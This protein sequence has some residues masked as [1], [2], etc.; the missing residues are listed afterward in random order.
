MIFDSD[1][2]AVSLYT[3]V[4]YLIFADLIL[5]FIKRDYINPIIYLLKF[6]HSE[7]VNVEYLVL[8]R[9]TSFIP[10]CLQEHKRLS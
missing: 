8:C 4:A 6:Y 2:V 5:D 3:I 7:E 9:C 1:F 10:D